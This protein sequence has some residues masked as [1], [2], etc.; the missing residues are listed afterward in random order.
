MVEVLAF[1]LSTEKP[2]GGDRTLEGGG[3]RVAMWA[4]IMDDGDVQRASGASGGI[5][6]ATTSAYRAILRPSGLLGAHR[7][8]RILLKRRPG[9]RRATYDRARQAWSRPHEDSPQS[10]IWANS[11]VNVNLSRRMVNDSS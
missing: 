2:K 6:A 7:P 10:G 9:C 3:S 8:I 1:M 4:D 11:L 5:A